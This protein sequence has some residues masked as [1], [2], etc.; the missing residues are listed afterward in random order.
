[1]SLLGSGMVKDGFGLSDWKEN[2]RFEGFEVK[3]I[4]LLS[5]YG[6]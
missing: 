3:W 6:E 1:M 4:G 2:G 5:G